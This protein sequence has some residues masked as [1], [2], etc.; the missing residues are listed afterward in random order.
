MSFARRILP[1]AIFTFAACSPVDLDSLTFACKTSADCDENKVCDPS[2]LVCVRPDILSDAGVSDAVIPDAGAD[3]G[4]DADA[5]TEDAAPG[6]GCFPPPEETGPETN[7][8]WCWGKSAEQLDTFLEENHARILDLT[9]EQTVPSLSYAA[10]VARRDLA[11]DFRWVERASYS[12]LRD[13]CRENFMLRDVNAFSLGGEVRWAGVFQQQRRDQQ[14]YIATGYTR[15][16]LAG[17]IDRINADLQP[18]SR[19]EFIDLDRFSASEGERYTLL[20][21]T[22]HPTRASTVAAALSETEIRTLMQD[23]L[24]LDFEA[25]DLVESFGIIHQQRPRYSLPQELVT[26]RLIEEINDTVRDGTYH[27]ER[28]VSFDVGGFRRYSAL[29]SRTATST[30]QRIAERLSEAEGT[31]SLFLAEV[32]GSTLADMQSEDVMLG[33]YGLAPAILAYGLK[34]VAEGTASLTATI[35]TYSAST[36]QACPSVQGSRPQTLNAQLVSLMRERTSGFKSVIAHFGA[37]NLNRFFEELGLEGLQI[38]GVLGCPSD[39]MT[40]SMGDLAR[41]YRRLFESFGETIREQMIAR[42]MPASIDAHEVLEVLPV[43]I[44]EEARRYRISDAVKSAYEKRVLLR[45]ARGAKAANGVLNRF[46]S[47]FFKVPDCS[48]KER[49]FVYGV[50]LHGAPSS[51]DSDYALYAVRAELLREVIRESLV[52]FQACAP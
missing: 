41:L 29:L 22:R 23:R 35:T 47:G 10:A 28:I 26:G 17:I 31:V 4:H 2:I 33:A 44:E 32:G 30:E 34:Q 37:E 38:E 49:V 48:Q 27:V 8:W 24:L 14:P 1:A 9:I 40:V 51:P 6:G 15:S 18:S 20:G 11:L 16:G 45:Y 19:A 50:A 43:I 3:G 39:G 52:A 7:Y 12:E 21:Y 36:D 25:T 5:A 46:H 13:V 42:M